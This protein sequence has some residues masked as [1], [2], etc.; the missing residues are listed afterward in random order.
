MGGYLNGLIFLMFL[1]AV[2]YSNNLLLIFTLMLF[3]MN[4]IWLVQTHFHLHGL[5][6]ESIHVEDG[7]AEEP[8]TIHLSWKKT[9][10]IPHA[11]E[12]DLEDDDASFPVRAILN[13]ETASMG[14]VTFDKRGFRKFKF[15]KVSSEM[16][17][18]LYK[19]WCYY[20]L[21]IGVFVFPKKLKYAS[22]LDQQYKGIE[23]EHG[24]SVKGPHDFLALAPY[25][26]EESKR[27][28]WKHYAK[29]G[30]LVIKEG[31]E[32]SKTEVHFSLPKEG[33]EK[34]HALCLLTTQ[35]IYCYRS[36][37]PF[38]LAGPRRQIPVGASQR[39]LKDCL[40]ELATC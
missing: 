10:K 3:G 30:E 34:E 37:I 7:H 33:P 20:R 28:S 19:T 16:P 8:Q 31:E 26:G 21:E 23:G 24:S 22:P 5:S 13:N 9:P 14:E 11:W 6:I 4:L 27:I 1:L 38:S 17:F 25:Q 18:G 2:G 29:S 12:V 35:M 40:R 15:I 39:H 32:N 36:Q